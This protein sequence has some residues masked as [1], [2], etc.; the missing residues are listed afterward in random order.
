MLGP[1]KTLGVSY[2]DTAEFLR[3]HT[4]AVKGSA[5]VTQQVTS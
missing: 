4:K 1:G 5:K 3:S 2:W